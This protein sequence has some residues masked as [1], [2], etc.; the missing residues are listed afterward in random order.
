MKLGP[1]SRRITVPDVIIIV[2]TGGLGL[3]HGQI[4]TAILCG[5]AVACAIAL[6]RLLWFIG[7]LYETWG[8]S[9][10]TEQSGDQI[11]PSP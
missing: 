5:C 3:I 1:P 10:D 4:W 2:T 8:P 9:E 7:R 11:T 6:W